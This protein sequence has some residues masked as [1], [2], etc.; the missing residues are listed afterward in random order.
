MRNFEKVKSKQPKVN[1]ND[2]NTEMSQRGR[3]L[4]KPKRETLK[5]QWVTMQ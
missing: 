2:L 1:F 3:K 4:N 5:R